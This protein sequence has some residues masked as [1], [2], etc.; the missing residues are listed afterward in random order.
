MAER[1]DERLDE[2]AARYF[3]LT[4]TDARDLIQ[5]LQTRQLRGGEWLMRQGEP[6]DALYFLVR[7]RLQVWLEAQAEVGG[8]TRPPARRDRTGRE[9]RR[10]RLC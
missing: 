5:A 9:R 3:G 7:G 2:I 4:G 1:S 8:A 6:A 10:A